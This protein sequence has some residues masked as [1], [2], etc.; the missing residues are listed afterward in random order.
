MKRVVPTEAYEHKRFVD[1]CRMKGYELHHSP[2][3]TASKRQGVK[4]KSNGTSAGFPDF[5]VYRNG[6]QYAIEMKRRSGGRI[7]KEQKRWIQLLATIGPAK[8]CN[9]F[10]EAKSF[11]EDV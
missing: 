10:E 9:G 7:S 1:Y 6:K 8:V 5:L 3:E 2:N 11:L 4:N